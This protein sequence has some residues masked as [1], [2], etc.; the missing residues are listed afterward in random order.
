M[1]LPDG[2]EE[3]RVIT[4]RLNRKII[5]QQTGAGQGKDTAAK[6]RPI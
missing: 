1:T 4:Y 2:A 5:T 6:V 3:L